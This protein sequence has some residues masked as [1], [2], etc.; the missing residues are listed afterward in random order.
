MKT[1]FITGATGV[2]GRASLD[3]VLARGDCRVRLLVRDSRKNR[4]MLRPY[5]RR[6]DVEV[7][8]GDLLDASAVVEALGDA[9]VVM[10][11]GGMVSPMAD[12]FPDRTLKVNVEG[13][14]NV[15]DAVKARPDR[16]EVRLFY[17]GS[18]AQTSLRNPPCHWGRAGDPLVAAEFDHYGLSKILAERVVA[19]SGLRRW[20]SLRQSGILHPGLFLRGSDPITFH[21]PLRGALEWAT[22]EDSGRLMAALCADS[23]PDEL[24]RGFFNIG[25]GA[26]YRLTNYEFECLILRAVGSPRPERIFEPS[27]FATRNFHGCWFAD[28]DRL[29]ELVPF[30]AGTP[31]DE[32]FRQMV[33][34]APW[35]TRLAPLAPAPLVKRMMRK[36]AMTKDHG[37]LDWFARTDK[38]DHIRAFFGSREE[39]DAIPTWKDIDLSRPSEVPQL[40]SHG[41]DDSKPDA[42][43]GLD[44]CRRTAEFRGGRCLAA[45]MEPGAVDEPVDWECAGGHRFSATPRM[46]L[47]GGHWCPSC[48][49]PPWN[50]RQEA[51]RNPFLAQLFSNP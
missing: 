14:A 51:A 7:V 45:A 46:V 44:D 41:Y 1:V 12:R 33:R 40:L 19:S 27:W 30:R 21:V 16:D 22:V 28:S 23:L 15:V 18:V 43:L 5:L 48:L 35:W 39:R 37:T 32:Y 36:V 25:S 50:P 31:V 9:S 34:R 47:R 11:M 6:G 24:W 49:P 38:E 26:P 2:M 17:I 13:T 42:E 10:H 20:V 4:R 8:W 29:E 3:A